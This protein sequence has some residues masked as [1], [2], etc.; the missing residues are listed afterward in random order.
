MPTE[1]PECLEHVIPIEMRW[2]DL[3]R[4]YKQDTLAPRP[5][6][7]LFVGNQ[8]QAHDGGLIVINVGELS[9]V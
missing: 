6:G 5:R 2:F 7:D 9:H 1:F 8:G 4:S 3:T